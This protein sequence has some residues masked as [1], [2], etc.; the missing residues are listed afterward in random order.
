MSLRSPSSYCLPN[1]TARIARAAFLRGNP[2]LRVYD[3]FGP[4]VANPQF[5]DLYP[6]EGQPAEDRPGWHWSRS[7]SSPRV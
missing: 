4:I 5:V 2:Y 3:A 1:E 6:N 7:F